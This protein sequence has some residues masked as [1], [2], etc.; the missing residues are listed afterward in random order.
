MKIQI[1]DKRLGSDWT[2]P[3]YKTDGSA[4]LDLRA[5]ALSEHDCPLTI[6]ITLDPGDTVLIGSGFAAEMPHGHAGF[7]FPRSGRGHK[8]GLVLGNGT[9]V[10]DSDYR[11]EIKVSAFNRHPTEAIEIV[12]GDRIAQLVIQP[13][14]RPE[15]RIVESLDDTERGEFGFGSTGVR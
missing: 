11:G 14:A 10:I 3:Q 6:P 1:M 4:G 9:G 7:I 12:P 5:M 13:I 15:F 2:L 8:D